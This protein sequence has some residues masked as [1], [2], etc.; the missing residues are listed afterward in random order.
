MTTNGRPQK[1][2][3][4]TPHQAST[5]RRPDDYSGDCRSDEEYAERFR[6]WQAMA[7]RRA[8]AAGRLPMLNGRVSA[9]GRAAFDP[10][11]ARPA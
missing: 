8:E 7:K 2:P 6:A 10:D 5:V 4:A 9:D 3:A 11:L 1:G